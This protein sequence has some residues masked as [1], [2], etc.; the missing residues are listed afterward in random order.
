LINS[1]LFDMMKAFLI[2]MLLISAVWAQ[3]A[4]EASIAGVTDL[5]ADNFD[6]IVGKEQAVLAE[7]YAPWCGHCKSLVP[8]YTKLGAAVASNKA[9]A[10]K[11]VIGKCNSE[12]HSSI[13]SRFGV[14]G[15]PTIKFFPA[16][17]LEA[18]DYEGGRTAEDFVKFLN[19]KTNAGIFIPRE[20]SD[21]VVLG[22]HNFDKI[23]KDANKDVLVKFYA[24][25][26]GHCKT[27]APVFDKIATTYKAE[28][29][30]VI[31]KVDADEAPNKPL[32]E[33]YGVTGFPTLKWFPKDNKAGEDYSGGRDEDAFVTFLNEKT[34][35]KRVLGGGLT[36]DAGTYA[37]CD[38]L[39]AGYL[40]ADAAAQKTITESLS[41]NA[42]CEKYAK[43]VAKVNAKG[44]S[45][46]SK[47]KARLSK[48]LDGNNIALDKQ[49]NFQIR[50]N[51]LSKFE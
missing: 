16:G 25:W 20:V 51:V 42:D 11:V 7:F 9:A 47:E 35:A 37:A 15:F 50:I 40:Q 4:P 26:C 38:A 41:A 1:Y 17:S 18:Q 6:E 24:P 5:T 32:A 34:G 44:D 39:A 43:V 33:T 30:I 49:D 14:Q 21:T 45:Y 29:N 22:P 8:E 13:G 23:V 28:A 2:A 19:E 36:E 10:A 48:M 46:I 27:L 31:A 12:E 3:D